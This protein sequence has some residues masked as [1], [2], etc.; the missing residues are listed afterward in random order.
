MLSESWGWERRGVGNQVE[1]CYRLSMKSFA[2]LIKEI[3]V[4]G[5]APL[6]LLFAY[7]YEGD[8]WYYGGKHED[9]SGHARK[10]RM[11]R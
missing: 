2:F 4:V 1:T 5:T 7:E 6:P 10:C 11:G 3:E 9:K 8:A